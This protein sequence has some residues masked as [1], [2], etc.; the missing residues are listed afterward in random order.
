MQVHQ[1]ISTVTSLLDPI[2]SH[3]SHKIFSY[4]KHDGAP[5]SAMKII[6]EL[7][8]TKEDYTVEQWVI[9]L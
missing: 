4:G 2:F 6:E 3:R 9:L 1:M 5:I 7:E 8:E